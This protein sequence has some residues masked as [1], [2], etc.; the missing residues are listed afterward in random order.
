MKKIVFL[1]II[2]LVLVPVSA[3][4][5]IT[6]NISTNEIGNVNYTFSDGTS[7]YSYKDVTGVTHY[8]F[9]NGVYGSAFTDITGNTSYYFDD[10][11][12]K[13][14]V[15]GTCFYPQAGTCM[16]ESQYE[17]MYA[18]AA[19]GLPSCNAQPSEFGSFSVPQ[20]YCTEEGRKNLILNGS[21]SS[22][23][24][25]CRESI[26]LYNKAK[27]RY[28]E[29]IE[30]QNKR[31]EEI[32]QIKLNAL[33]VQLD[34]ERQRLEIIK[35]QEATKK[36]VT[37]PENS[38]LNVEGNCNCDN[39]YYYNASLK[40]CLIIKQTEEQG[41]VTTSQ[42]FR[43]KLEKTMAEEEKKINDTKKIIESKPIKIELN[44]NVSSSEELIIVSNTLNLEVVKDQIVEEK[45]GIDNKQKEKVNIFQKAGN[46]ADDISGFFKKVFNKIKFW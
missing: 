23:L 8:Q 39:G 25:M 35:I 14:Y 30:E 29:C 26:D 2:S 12:R 20:E 21:Y 45:K 17:E 46:L 42:S 41:I 11:S 9:N 6:G 37:C 19:E 36:L 40:S 1:I 27:V 28:S 13:I 7:G 10:V 32:A 16:Y 34:N 44:K 38:Y 22:W 18:K 33:K 5:L 43:E 15:N 24:K 3:F 4:A 31:Y